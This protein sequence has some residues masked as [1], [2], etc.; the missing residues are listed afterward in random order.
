MFQHLFRVHWASAW[1]PGHKW[2]EIRSNTGCD[3]NGSCGGGR[4]RAF[5][6]SISKFPQLNCKTLSIGHDIHVTN[7][8]IAHSPQWRDVTIPEYLT[9]KTR[10]KET[11]LTRPW[12]FVL[13]M[14][15]CHWEETSDMTK[16]HLF[17]LFNMTFI[18]PC[19][20]IWRAQGQTSI[21]ASQLQQPPA[22]WWCAGYNCWC[23]V[24]GI[25]NIHDYVSVNLNVRHQTNM[26]IP[27]VIG[28][29]IP[30]VYAHWLTGLSMVLFSQMFS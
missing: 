5:G 29:I 14:Y 18:N 20:R 15:H 17:Y 30:S 16:W 7:I 19:T 22:Q 11:R 26:Q 2:N 13:P 10:M 6:V 3:N 28:I 4:E 27:L 23:C 25:G 8:G 12:Y 21:L 9:G 1:S 24:P